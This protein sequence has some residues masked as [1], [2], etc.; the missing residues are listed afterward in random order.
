MRKD[1]VW[2]GGVMNRIYNASELEVVPHYERMSEYEKLHIFATI[3]GYLW[4]KF[5][6]TLVFSHFS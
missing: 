6:N 1:Y 2:Q 4:G 3:H 5:Y